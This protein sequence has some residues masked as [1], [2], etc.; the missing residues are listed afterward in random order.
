MQDAGAAHRASCTSRWRSAP[1]TRR[2]IPSRSAR[3][4]VAQLGRRGVRDDAATR[5][6]LQ[7]LRGTAP[8][9]ARRR[10]PRWPRTCWRR[11]QRAARAHRPR[12]GH[13]QRARPEDAAST[14]TTHLRPGAGRAQRLRDHRLRGRAVAAA[15]RAPRQAQ[16]AARRGRHAALVRLRAPRGAAAG[17]A[18]RTP[19]MPSGWGGRRWPVAAS[20]R[21]QRSS[22][23]IATVALA[24]G[25]YADAAAFEDAA[26]PLL[27][28]F[29]L[30]KALYELRYEL[31]NRPDWVGVPLAG[32]AELAERL[33]VPGRDASGPASGA[34]CDGQ[35]L[36]RACWN[37]CA[38]VA[39]ADRRLPAAA[40]CAARSA[41]AR[42]RLADRQGGALRVSSRRCAR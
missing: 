22:R 3:A 15:R 33:G 5:S 10:S 23:P 4:D 36:Q 27:T 19:P 29:E 37:R 18:L 2:S 39:A 7:Q 14:A 17:D 41:A 30:E 34:N 16:R 20:A 24:G 28:L 35:T 1:A 31:N 26:R 8:A 13:C 38:H 6:T 12:C 42:R 11:A 21:A 9:S 25:L 32:I 40:G